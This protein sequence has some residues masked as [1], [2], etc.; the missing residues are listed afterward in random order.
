MLCN[1]GTGSVNLTVAGGTGVYTYLW[2]NGAVTEDLTVVSAGVFSVTVTDAN[3]CTATASATVTQPAALTLNGTQSNV[4]CNGGNSGSINITVGGGTA[5]YSYLWSNGAV[6]EDINGLIAGNYDAT[7][8][9]ANGCIVSSSFTISQPSAI[10]SSIVGTDVTC[11]GAANG[12]ATLSVSGGTSPYTYLWSNFASTQNVTNVSGGQYFVIITDANG[13]IKRDSIVI[14]EP[15]GVTLSG[16]VTNVSCNGAA[17]GA[18]DITATGGTPTFTF[19]WSNGDN[20]EDL[21][22]LAAGVYTV[23][24]TDG[25][26]CIKT[27]SFI[28]AQPAQALDILLTPTDVNCNG[29]ANGSIT[30]VVTGGTSPYSFVWSNGATTSDLTGLSAGNFVVT[31]S[32]VNGCID[33]DSAI[34][35]APAILT[36]SISGT[37]VS[38]FG[39]NDGSADLTVTGGNAPYDYFWSTF[40]FTE[41]LSKLCSDCHRC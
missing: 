31:V 25:N 37:D 26:G 4:L 29:G 27:L 13:C 22:G 20:T 30:S 34:V 3:N 32:D 33:V 19:L 15:T 2:S 6:T 8:T 5:S 23:T 41:D 40:E 9:D 14:A 39:G 12:S 7:V 36:A 35:N 16:V 28:I 17:D 18:I 38:C 24:L 11:N 21:S 1:G 10:T